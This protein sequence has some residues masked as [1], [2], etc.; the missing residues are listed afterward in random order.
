MP[1]VGGWRSVLKVFQD[2]YILGF[3]QAINQAWSYGVNA[4]YRK[5]NRAVE[6]TRINHIPDCPDY[7]S[8]PI[9]NPGETNKPIAVSIIGDLISEPTETFFVNLSNSTTAPIADAQ[10]VGTILNDDGGAIPTVGIDDIEIVET[11]NGT[12]MAS[13]AA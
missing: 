9:I 5:V 3:Q 2:E 12:A 4:T 10:G 8:F 1:A 11:D 7:S 6:D 13:I